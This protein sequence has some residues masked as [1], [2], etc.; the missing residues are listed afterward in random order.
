MWNE[1]LRVSQDASPADWLASRLIGPLGTVTDT[2][3]S[4]YGAYA[5]IVHPSEHDGRGWSWSEVAQATG[6]RTHPLMQWHALVGSSDPDNATDS[7]WP[8][9]NPP[10]GHLSPDLLA[11]LC[12]LLIGYTATPERCFFCLWDGYAWIDGAGGQRITVTQ[13]DGEWVQRVTPLEPAFSDDE[14]SRPRVQLP[15]RGYLLFTGSLVALAESL[16]TSVRTGRWPQSDELLSQSPNLF[17]PADR[18][19]CVASEIDFDSTLV[20]GTTELVETILQAPTLDSWP[21][22]PD[23]SLTFDADRINPVS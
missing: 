19:W 2:V 1:A 13:S 7:L 9:G 15:S 14:L 6:R 5:R 10:R 18:A 4:G 23:D 8:G 11:P 12:D 17:W 22:G 16:A 3:P 21:V 20:G